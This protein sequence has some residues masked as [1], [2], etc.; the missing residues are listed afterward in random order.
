MR[1]LLG[2]VGAVIAT[3]LGL[4]VLLSVVAVVLL[5]SGA[6][7]GLIEGAIAAQVGRPAQPGA[8]AIRW[9]SRTGP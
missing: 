6:L 3:M 5:N 7:N 1:K 8:G 2:I 4:V 9:V